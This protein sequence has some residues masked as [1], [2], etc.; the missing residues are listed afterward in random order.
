[1]KKLN[2]SP[3]LITGILLA[4][5][6]AVAFIFR[7][8][9]SFGEIFK[10]DWIKYNGAD[11]YFQMRLADVNAAHYPHM[12]SFDPYFVYPG[13]GAVGGLN[14]FPRII[15]SIASLFGIFNPDQRALDIVGVF[16]PPILAVLTVIIVFFIGRE[17]FGRW[18]GI[19][20]ATMTAI[21]PGEFLS[22]TK[23]GFTDY[24]VFEVFITSLFI[25][26]IIL[27][28]KAAKNNELKFTD[29]IKRNWTALKRPA[30]FSVLAALSFV[31]Y[32]VSWSG[33]PLFLFV[34][35]SF[36]IVQFISDHLRGR[37]TDYLA[38]TGGIVFLLGLL[39]LLAAPVAGVVTWALLIGFTASV[40]LGVL[41]WFMSSRKLKP[42]WF[43]LSILVLGGAGFGIFYAIFPGAADSL[44]QSFAIFNPAGAS[45]TTI[46]MQPLISGEYGNPFTVVWYN[47]NTTFFLAWG[48]LAI[49]IY[50][51]VKK[52]DSE[53]TLLLVWSVI[54][55]IANL[56]QRRF[57][58]Y[59]AINISL[60]VGYLSWLAIDYARSKIFTE[61]LKHAMAKAKEVKRK[62]LKKR[63]NQ[64]FIAPYFTMSLVAVI[65]FFMAYFWSIQPSVEAAQGVPFAPTDAWQNALDWMRENTP[66]PFG[67]AD[68][69]YE[70]R[71]NNDYLGYTTLLSRYPEEAAVNP[72]FYKELDEYYP[73]PDTAYG[74][75]SWWDY[76]YWITRIA[77]RL[78]NANPSQ[79]PRAIKD[80]AEFF[81]AKDEAAAENVRERLD[82]R[83]IVI[84]NPTAYVPPST[85]G[86][87]YWAIITWADQDVADYFDV[88][89]VPTEESGNY[90]QTILYHPEYYR[91]MA[92]RL[93]NFDCQAYVPETVTVVGYVTRQDED[94]N[95][96]KVVNDAQGFTTYEEA[97]AFIEAKE[98]GDYRIVGTDPMVSCVPLE[99]LEDYRTVFNSTEGS[100]LNSDNLTPEVKIFEYTK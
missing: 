77:Q 22:R 65:V 32:A 3:A 97:L 63:S 64:S 46:E 45:L 52:G 70:F 54:I 53:K 19:L 21:I 91:S 93:Y 34:A 33:S 18:G 7:V 73:Y 55:L 2:I 72:Q 48:S 31:L 78:P 23:L 26:F 38:I 42:V 10:G 80:V 9:F 86:G 90:R 4:I 57:G 43:P 84:D 92:V 74:V 95:S 51:L 100:Y 1:M 14:Y 24:H 60:L 28:L 50:G 40:I 58:Y 88:Y 20:A 81:L 44:L 98:E 11:A 62:V 99:S 67:D 79:D 47:Y 69:Y 15:A 41:S 5:I 6:S 85:G 82:T 35:F 39:I 17:I 66:E 68:A 8:T 61:Q 76:G 49:L 96:Y 59:F 89:L 37:R 27:A 75:L 16:I 29:I 36:F 83:Y 30:I 87:K 25:L 94:G 56:A 12:P 13:G 71:E